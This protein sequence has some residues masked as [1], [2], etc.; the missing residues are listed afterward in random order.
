ME[1]KPRRKGAMRM[2]DIPPDM[3]SAVQGAPGLSVVLH[4]DEW[5]Q[6]KL[7]EGENCTRRSG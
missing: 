6:H 7:G 2:A 4:D 3:L 1:S 5:C